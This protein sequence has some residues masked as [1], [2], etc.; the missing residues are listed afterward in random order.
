[1]TLRRW[2]C[3]AALLPCWVAY[4]IAASVVDPNHATF[5]QLVDFAR[6]VLSVGTIA[7]LASIYIVR[8]V[9]N[10]LSRSALLRSIRDAQVEH[11]A[12]FDEVT[13]GIPAIASAEHIAALAQMIENAAIDRD[14]QIARLHDLLAEV[15]AEAKQELHQSMAW[16][17][18]RIRHKEM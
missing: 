15:R 11:K 9:E 12:A 1:M 18:D 16:V 6:L 4:Y 14:Q 8:S 7:I 5:T 2:L 17:L 3:I 10:I 13:G